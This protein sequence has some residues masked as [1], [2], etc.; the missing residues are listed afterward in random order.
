MNTGEHPSIKAPQHHLKS[1]KAPWLSPQAQLSY[2]QELFFTWMKE[3]TLY[4]CAST[5]VRS[6]HYSILS[7]GLD[8]S[9]R[10]KP[11]ALS[12]SGL[13]LAFSVDHWSRALGHK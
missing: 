1:G 3:H 5:H 4:L 7:P 12:P 8:I 11:T 13:H 9:Q 6:Q 10:A 2:Q